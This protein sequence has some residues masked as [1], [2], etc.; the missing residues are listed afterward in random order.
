MP[1]LPDPP[2]WLAAIQSGRPASVYLIIGDPC[3]TLPVHRQLIEALL[4]PENRDLTWEQVDGE[5]E[6]V[7]TLVERLRTFPL[8][9]GPKVVSVRNLGLLDPQ[10]D[11]KSLLEKARE[12]WEKG[13]EGRSR[14]LLARI[15]SESGAS[16]KALGGQD[17]ESRRNQCLQALGDLHE[18]TAPEWLQK[19]L[20]TWDQGPYPETSGPAELLEKAFQE[21]LPSGH[22]LV[23]INEKV[24]RQKKIFRFLEKTGVLL[25]QT[26]KT[27]NKKEQTAAFKQYLRELLARER[28]TIAPEA[29][30]LL[31]ERLGW[32]PGL[33]AMEVGKLAV[34]SGERGRITRDD[35][36]LLVGVSREEPFYELTAA[37]GEKNPPA[38][39]RILQRLWEQGFHPLAILSG[40]TNA[41][42][43]LLVAREW[44]DDSQPAGPSAWK[45]YSSFRQHILPRL[46]KNPPPGPWSHLQPYALFTLLNSARL[47]SP[48][49]S[50]RALQALQR[51]D[52]RL[53]TTGVEA[54]PLLEDFIL[55]R[56]RK[57]GRRR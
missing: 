2:P 1:F 43:R 48:G 23:L 22:V 5:I 26:I 53:K 21:G 24:G 38:A 15:W 52:R 3:L 41:F 8:F 57:P 30:A 11:R 31:L 20:D 6:E 37:L 32:E 7:P 17:A 39:L 45:D 42:R 51:M 18:G 4:P 14:R 40:V 54:R 12:A 29:E 13:E 55:T 36:V 35:V 56:C 27:G 28:K 34:Y 25:D 10:E 47:F 50:Y 16:L 19:A 44:L 33:L 9:P 46:Q 49:E